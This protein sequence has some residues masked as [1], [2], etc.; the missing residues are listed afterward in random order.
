MREDP[1][2]PCFGFKSF[3]TFEV[4]QLASMNEDRGCSGASSPWLTLAEESR[5]KRHQLTVRIEPF[6]RV[7]PWP[8]QHRWTLNECQQ[9]TTSLHV[10]LHNSSLTSELFSC[11]LLPSM[12]VFFSMISI[13]LGHLLQVA[14]SMIHS[15]IFHLSTFLMF[16]FLFN[17]SFPFVSWIILV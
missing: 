13:W 9:A 5:L 17:S 14:H 3:F 1:Q 6:S 10:P 15:V 2:T 8:Q 4:P 11:P 16:S 7:L 12:F